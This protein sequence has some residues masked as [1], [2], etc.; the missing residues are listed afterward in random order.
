MIE[1]EFQSGF[2]LITLARSGANALAAARTRVNLARKTRFD[3][4]VPH[5]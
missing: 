3:H 5:K 1:A 2:L 4:L